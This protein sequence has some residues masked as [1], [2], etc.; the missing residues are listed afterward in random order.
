MSE[1]PHLV[2]VDAQMNAEQLRQWG[3]I[4]ND[5]RSHRAKFLPP[6]VDDK[7]EDGPA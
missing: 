3:A 5:G 1:L 7:L 6:E 4:F 2:Q